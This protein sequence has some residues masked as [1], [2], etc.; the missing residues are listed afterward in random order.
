MWQEHKSSECWA[1]RDRRLV[2]SVRERRCYICHNSGHLANTCDKRR[3]NH[4]NVAN[5]AVETATAT[6]SPSSVACA[7]DEEVDS[8]RVRANNGIR[9]NMA[10]GVHASDQ[11]S[12]ILTSKRDEFRCHEPGKTNCSFIQ[13]P[14]DASRMP[15]VTA[16]VNDHVVKALRDS[17][18]NTILVKK[19]FVLPEQFTGEFR[20]V[21]CVNNAVIRTPVAEIQ[22]RTPFITGKVEALC[23]NDAVYDLIIGNVDGLEGPGIASDFQCQGEQRY[24]ETSPDISSDDGKKR[25]ATGKEDLKNM[26]DDMGPYSVE[27]NAIMS[28]KNPD[29]DKHVNIDRDE[30]TRLQGNDA[31]LRRLMQR[32]E[33]WKKGKSS[34]KVVQE[35]GIW[36]REFTHP[37]WN[38]G[39]A[40]RQVLLPQELRNTVLAIAHESVFGAHMGIGKTLDK[41]L[42][43]FFWP[44]IHGD[45]TR[46]VRSCDTCQKTVRRGTV[47]KATLGQMPIIGTCWERIGIDLVGPIVPASENGY[48]YILTVVDHATRYPEAVPLRGCSTEDVAE[49]LFD[50]YCRLGIPSEILSDMGRQFIS[51]CMKQVSELLGIKQLHTSVYHPISNG[52][53]E[54]YNSTM[55]RMLRRLCTEQPR[56]WDKYLGALLFAYREV[57]QDSTGFSPFELLYGRTVRG[58]LQILK[59]LWSEE[60]KENEI[61][62]TYQYVFDLKE[63]LEATLEMAHSQLEQSQK[64]QKQY[65]DRK[66]RDRSFAVGDEVL[67]ML[68]TEQNKL[69]MQ[70][71]GPYKIVS[72][73]GTLDY[74]VQLG[75]KTKTYH[76]NL[77]KPYVR[78][79]IFEKNGTN[80]QVIK[81]VNPTVW[82]SA[83]VAVVDASEGPPDGSDDLEDLPSCHPKESVSDVKISDTLSA[84]EQRQLR[85]LLQSFD[86]VIT[87]LPGNCNLTKHRIILTDETP[88]ASRPYPVPY[89]VRESLDREIEE[90]LRLGVVRPSESPYASPVVIVKK[91]DGSNRICIDYRKLNKITVADPEPMPMIKDAFQNL[92]HENFFSKLDLSKGYWQIEMDERDIAKTAFVTHNAKLEFIRMPFGTRS[93]G[94]TLMRCMRKLLSGVKNVYNYIDDILIHTQDWEEHLK[95]LDVVFSRLRDAGLTVRPSKCEFG[96][97]NIEFVGH[98]VGRGVLEINE[99]NARKII[100]SERPKTKKEVRSF[101][102]LIGFYRDFIPNFSEKAAPLTD[103]TRNKLPNKIQWNEETE[104]AYVQL[105]SALMSD[106]V[107]RLFDEKKLILLRTDA[108]D[109]G[110][111]CV[112]MQEHEQWLPVCY[113][114]R[115]LL[116]REKRYSTIEKECL[117]IVWS[118]KKFQLYLYGREFIIQT[119]HN[120]LTFINKAKFD[121]ARVMRWSLFLQQYT[122]RIEEIKGKHNLEADYLSRVGF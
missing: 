106:P 25:T 37:H 75:K 19:K 109:I 87:D 74:G 21:R 107:L 11:S 120:S 99:G 91:K 71:R 116:D 6:G 18:C 97:S 51:E 88:I 28:L 100:T 57:P 104:K 23:L 82:E 46:F 63:K 89:A 77:L 68:P 119:D 36:Y 54:K 12:D 90:M 14:S 31:S 117:A 70:W 122:F 92:G 48:R 42:S 22:I 52:L 10:R 76:V 55:K 16:T 62:N 58:P 4:S 24:E 33:P 118:V 47:S 113:A 13:V 26:S 53:V 83:N 2:D 45:V 39:N 60:I 79:E 27:A 121:N 84:D 64:R 56:Q 115:K 8:P 32:K 9:E 102:A 3:S 95:T 41:I 1:R 81:D 20:S 5:N 7:M 50:I 35:K 17:G 111:G 93:A 101:V 94:A 86:D 69:L 29:F 67:L 59:E 112:L 110:L 66:A 43:C 15:V 30:L 34:I 73:K 85:E 78:R 49:A 98:K 65:Y 72:K 61:K 44:G 96:S 103:L 108:S 105:I 80:S 40:V 38:H 114:S